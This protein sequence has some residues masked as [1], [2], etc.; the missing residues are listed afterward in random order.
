MRNFNYNHIPQQNN[1]AIHDNNYIQ[2]N[3]CNYLLQN[4]KNRKYFVKVNNYSIQISLIKYE[5][6]FL[7]SPPSHPPSQP[8]T[9]YTSATAGQKVKQRKMEP[10]NSDENQLAL[11]HHA[12]KFNF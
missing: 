9:R 6:D 7:K 4:N 8:P 5:D 12:K 3:N 11:Q 10:K 2:L 1:C